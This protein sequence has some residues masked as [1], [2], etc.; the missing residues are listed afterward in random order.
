[1]QGSGEQD[2]SKVGGVNGLKKFFWCKSNIPSP[3]KRMV[4]SN[5]QRNSNHT[6]G[7]KIY[8]EQIEVIADTCDTICFETGIR[9]KLKLR[10]CTWTLKK[11]SECCNIRQ[12]RNESGLT[13][14][15]S[16]SKRS[17]IGTSSG[18][19]RYGEIFDKTGWHSFG[20]KVGY[21]R[22]GLW[23]V[24]GGRVQDRKRVGIKFEGVGGGHH[25][26]GGGGGGGGGW[27]TT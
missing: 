14:M 25:Y 2:A 10:Y 24:L 3:K 8:R 11:Y 21:F 26:G 22:R 27:G 1:V 20:I 15:T 9:K 16:P 13:Q 12:G 19:E 18:Y 5:L 17:F 7:N 4:G 6:Y 23:D